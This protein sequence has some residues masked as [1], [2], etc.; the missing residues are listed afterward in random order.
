[1][2]FKKYVNDRFFVIAGPCVVESKEICLEV[3]NELVQISQR[4]NIPIIFKASYKKA[5]RT[6]GNSFTGIGDEGALEILSQIKKETGLPILTD[7][8]EVKD[9]EFVKD[10]VDIF[11]IPAFLCRQTDLIVA[12]ALTGQ[13][14]NIKK[15]QFASADIMNHAIDKVKATGN[16]QGMLTERGTFLGYE[17]LVVDMR[18]IAKMKISDAPVI[19][20]ATHSV[21][22]PGKAGGKSGGDRNMIPTLTYAALAAGADG[23]FIETHPEPSKG[24]S[25]AA[26]MYPLKDLE[27][28]LMNSKRVYEMV[29]G[30]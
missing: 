13:P 7:V 4:L 15:G 14:V 25:D 16:Q 28:L 22:E 21:Q 10:V 17:D 19:Y 29:R 27:R 20:D 30:F 8:H 18:N 3:A 1:M 12:A 2:D 23:L 24:L 5:N 11:Q 6:S 9:I 26:T